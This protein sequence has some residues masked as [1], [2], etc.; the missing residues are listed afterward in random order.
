VNTAELR[1]LLPH[2][3]IKPLS[4]YPGSSL[5]TIIASQ[6]R[7]TTIGAYN[8]VLV[9]F[10]IRYPPKFAMS[11]WAPLSQAIANNYTVYIYQRFV[12]EPKAVYVHE[13]IFSE[14]ATFAKIHFEDRG[15]FLQ[16][17][18]TLEESSFLSLCSE[19]LPLSHQTPIELHTYSFKGE[20]LKHTLSRYVAYYYGSKLWNTNTI[21][22]FGDHPTV[23]SLKV[24]APQFKSVGSYYANNLIANHY[25]PDKTWNINTR[26]LIETRESN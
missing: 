13:H 6:H 26:V 2:L 15:T 7:N 1:K 24:L 11:G 21:L 18:V 25:L 12:D 14:P 23:N 10:P 4:I 9:G 22:N 20:N 19:K 16:T 3:S 8:S 17:T 5:L